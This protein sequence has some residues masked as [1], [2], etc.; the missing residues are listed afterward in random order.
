M[1]SLPS[2]SVVIPVLDGARYLQELLE[3]LAREQ[4]DEVLVIDSGSSD[5]SPQI[6]SAAGVELLQI[7]PS[8]FGHG[9]TRNLGAERTRGELI[10][11]LTQDATPLPGW[12]AALREAF[13]L[14]ERIGAVYGPHRPRPDTSP[15]IARE[16]TEFF[17]G[18][19]PGG[20]PVVQG[21]SDSA[22]LSNV[23][24]AY[25]RTCWEEVRFRDLAYAEDQAF[26]AD[27]LAAGWKK[28]YQPEAAVL[29][30]HDYGAVDFMRRYFDEYRGLRASIGHVEPF[31]PRAVLGDVR[32]LVGADV[33]WMQRAGYPP[34][35]RLRWGA[36][37]LA[38]H[39]GRKAS[40]AL[41]SRAAS[42]PKPLRRRM[43]FE[44]SD[45]APAEAPGV[46]Q[47]Q[48]AGGRVSGR[49]LPAQVP[50]HEYDKIA[51]VLRDGPAPLSDPLPG[52]AERTPLHVAF[53][54]PPF[55]AG[56]GGHNIIFQLTQRLERAGHTCSIWVE[57]VFG[58]RRHEWPGVVRAAIREHFA[59]VAA[60]VYN[61]FGHWYGADVVVATGWETVYAAL[62]LPNV[63]ARAYLVNDHEPEFFPTSVESVWAADTYRQGLYGICGSPWLRDLYTER[64]GG[65]AEVFDYGVDHDVYFPHAVERERATVVYYC[66][67]TTPRRAVALGL[68]ALEELYRR[69]PQT[70]IVMFGEHNEMKTP[71][72]YEHLGVAAPAT[73]ARLFSQA[74]VGL[75]LSMTNYSLIPQEMLACGLPCVDLEGASAESVFGGDGPVEL[76]EF[77]SHALA[78]HVGRLLDDEEL[79]QRR[80][81]AGV[82]FVAGRSWDRA[83]EQVEGA[84]RR[85]LRQREAALL[86]GA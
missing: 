76:S 7:E 45:Y 24:A 83:A 52:M 36:R 75:C 34:A 46:H 6:A 5:G 55:G 14:D 84:L 2:T 61:D 66:R 63:R 43:S 69:R 51:R 33:R 78:G 49:A 19:S 35:S 50:A 30:A 42:L 67:S 32:A 25:R 11:F 9:R 13:A 44:G 4:P 31:A 22:F 23:N 79:W 73:L 26:G 81:R 59:P 72:P 37:S 39:S 8:E 82:E 48:E 71:F 29:H 10:C 74:T 3:A 56:S 17:A 64:Y 80:S 77:D 12:L 58:H 85:A 68:M 47:P 57:D 53:V 40:S 21:P 15:M 86:A 38:H 60:P 20:G 16:L 18:F 54:I 62:D 1:T 41:G 27:M 28:A 65:A 70:R